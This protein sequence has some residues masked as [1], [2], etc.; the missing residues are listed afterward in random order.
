MFTTGRPI[1]TNGL[2]IACSHRRQYGER[3]GRHWLDLARY[4]DS[5]GYHDDAPTGDLAIP[6]LR[7]RG[8]NDDMP[9]DRFTIEQIAGD[10]LPNATPIN[11]SPPV[12]TATLRSIKRA[13]STRS[14]SASRRSSTA[15]P[16]PERFVWG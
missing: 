12:S 11:R 4:A 7:D 13:E 3:W 14:N 16:R 5:D 9:F 10:L 2:S 6:R 1:G 15:L 8:L